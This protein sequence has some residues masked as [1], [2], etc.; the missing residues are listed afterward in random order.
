MCEDGTHFY[1]GGEGRE[2]ALKLIRVY[3]CDPRHKTSPP[4]PAKHVREKIWR[5]HGMMEGAKIQTTT[6]E[7]KIAS[8]AYLP[9][10]CL[11]YILCL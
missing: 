4:R 2:R 10:E 3:I 6:W 8:L 1:W 9:L 7:G 5:K 11:Q